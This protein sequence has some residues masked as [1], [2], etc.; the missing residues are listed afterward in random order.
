MS[1][2]RVYTSLENKF[3]QDILI[4]GNERKKLNRPG[5]RKLKRVERSK[6]V[7]LFLTHDTIRFTYI[8]DI[9]KETSRDQT[10][11]QK[12]KKKKKPLQDKYQT[13]HSCKFDVVQS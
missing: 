11:L 5:E 3:E 13:K 8:L 2:D 12:K 4:L 9:K 10:I 1:R 7:F 6:T